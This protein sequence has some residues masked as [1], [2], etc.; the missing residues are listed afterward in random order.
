[1]IKPCSIGRDDGAGMATR[2]DQ[3]ATS[4][5][6]VPAW[7][8]GAGGARTLAEADALNARGVPMARGGSWAQM[9]VKRVLDR[10][11]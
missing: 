11:R 1:V 2:G 8:V 6:I 4:R 9:A 5:E 7:S 10:A 3:S